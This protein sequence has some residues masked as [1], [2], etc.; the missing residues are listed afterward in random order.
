MGGIKGDT[1]SVY[2][3]A[4][5]CFRAC[6]IPGTRTPLLCPKPPELRIQRL[7]PGSSSALWWLGTGLVGIWGS[8]AP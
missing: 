6:R 4:D 7:L 8:T 5:V 2:P 3:G 1:R